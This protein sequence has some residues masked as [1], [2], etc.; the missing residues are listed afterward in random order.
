MDDLGIGIDIGASKIVVAVC[1]GDKA[2]VIL[3]SEGCRSTKF[4]VA[5]NNKERLFSDAAEG[6]FSVNPENTIYGRDVKQIIG[7]HKQHFEGKMSIFSC[8]L[9]L[10][11]DPEQ[12]R[13]CLKYRNQEPK[14]FPEHILTMFLSKIKKELEIFYKRSVSKAVITVPS[15]FNSA[16]RFAVKNAVLAAGI[17]VESI[18]NDSTASAITYMIERHGSDDKNILIFDMGATSTD[19]AVIKLTGNSVEVKACGGNLDLGGDSFVLLLLKY[20][21]REF[22]HEKN[23]RISDNKHYIAR[24]RFA[25]EKFKKMLSATSEAV[26]HVE[27]FYNGEPYQL[28]MKRETFETICQNLFEKVEKVIGDVIRAAKCSVDEV[29]VVGNGGRIPKVEVTI[30]EFCKKELSKVLNQDESVAMGAAYYAARNISKTYRVRSLNVKQVTAMPLNFGINEN[31]IITLIKRGKFLPI[32]DEITYQ[33]LQKFQIKL[34]Q[35]DHVYTCGVL[36]ADPYE[37]SSDFDKDGL[38]KLT[39]MV[40]DV[41]ETQNSLINHQKISDPKIKQIQTTESMFEKHE[42]EYKKAMEKKNDLEKICLVYKRKF[43]SDEMKDVLPADDINKIKNVCLETLDWLEDN[44]HP[45]IKDIEKKIEN[46]KEECEYMIEKS[47]FL[48]KLQHADQLFDQKDYR[49]ASSIYNHILNNFSYYLDDDRRVDIMFKSASALM[50][51][52]QFWECIKLL[53]TLFNST[54]DDLYRLKVCRQRGICHFYLN[55]YKECISD[56]KIVLNYES[57]PEV[58]KLFDDAIFQQNVQVV[59]NMFKEAENLTRIQQYDQS[60]SKLNDLYLYKEFHFLVKNGN[61]LEARVFMLRAQNNFM[62]KNYSRVLK[63]CKIAEKDPENRTKVL[64]FRVKCFT[65]LEDFDKAEEQ[66][67]SLES[68][69]YNK[70]RLNDFKRRLAGKKYQNIKAEY[71]ELFKNEQYKSALKV[72]EEIP[73]EALEKTLKIDHFCNQAA[74]FL[75]LNKFSEGL[76]CCQKA[77]NVDKK[78][79]RALELRAECYFHKGDNKKAIEE[80]DAVLKLPGN[81]YN[82]RIRDIKREAERAIESKKNILTRASNAVVNTAVNVASGIYQNI[83]LGAKKPEEEQKCDLE[84]EVETLTGEEAWKDEDVNMESTEAINNQSNEKE[85]PHYA[86]PTE[87]SK[88]KEVKKETFTS[89]NQQNR[90]SQRNA[91]KTQNYYEQQDEMDIDYETNYSNKNRRTK[92]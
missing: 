57:D 66:L 46:I 84:K 40:Q 58:Q 3:N 88:S 60:N 86:L 37:I 69:T 83:V 10:S 70:A 4:C 14:L 17:E 85:Q 78:H 25:C 43:N 74:A 27:T 48:K 67:A 72:L 9:I 41:L 44:S 34:S 87:A 12:V 30:A 63:D 92:P 73:V 80:C 23:V 62:M 6:Q 28:K 24:L 79:C 54:E 2:E 52:K 91:G 90:R 18:L 68:I 15:M 29:I 8:P 71:D 50:E 55:N 42:I 56:L 36:S 89:E 31:E 5:F 64:E 38:L 45:E 32:N 1:R 19:V 81:Y 16:Q 13:Y 65:E 39:I 7:L 21:I 20:F 61:N 59:E 47:E 22:E 77:L 76:E 51:T 53:N 82:S 33:N 11:E 75:V 35:G 49:E 26:L